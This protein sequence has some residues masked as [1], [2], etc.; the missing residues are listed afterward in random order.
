[1]EKPKRLNCLRRKRY[2]V[3]LLKKLKLEDWI[4]HVRYGAKFWNCHLALN[5]MILLQS[6]I[7]EQKRG[8]SSYSSKVTV[9]D[10]EE[11]NFDYQ[12]YMN[13]ILE[14]KGYRFFQS[15][16]DGDEKGTSLSVNH[17]FWGTWVTYIGYFMLFLW[18]DG[19]Y[20]W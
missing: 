17:D 1:M 11:G 19:Y 10:E 12:I 7:Q 13:H 15:S 5:L 6:D 3:S 9:F 4:L 20:V 16:F 2:I 14:H 18:T 8:Y